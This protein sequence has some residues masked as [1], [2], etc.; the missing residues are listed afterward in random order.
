MSK[1]EVK[2]LSKKIKDNIIL[3]NINVSFEGGNIYGIYGRN[4]S[5][6]TMFFRAI[7]G[8]IKPDE[9]QV[10]INNRIL[11][12]DIDFPESCGVMLESP[13]FWKEYS[14]FENLKQLSKIK[15]IINDEQIR[16]V[17]NKVGLNCDDKKIF[18]KFSLGMKQKLG[19]A[20][21][22]MEMPEILI[23]DEPTNALDDVSINNIRKIIKEQKER[24]AIVL[25]ASH[26]KDDINELADVKLKM[27][28]GKLSLV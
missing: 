24:G 6:K 12:K 7:C 20:Q 9:G 11:G 18:G 13:G 10:V 4:A 3:D 5:G 22:L 28:Q 21:A 1:I 25:I 15:N 17:I 19:I 27:N 23:L 2:G 16:D 26:N 14:A 8:L